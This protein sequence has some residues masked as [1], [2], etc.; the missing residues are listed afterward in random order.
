MG[1]PL[2]N[3]NIIKII[4]VSP[5]T[6]RNE[7]NKW[8]YIYVCIYKKNDS[9]LV[10]VYKCDKDDDVQRG[11]KNLKK[12]EMKRYLKLREGRLLRCTFIKR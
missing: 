7:E 6:P 2:S 5:I 12:N 9:K 10:K 11:K 3:L 8:E 4:V 1:T